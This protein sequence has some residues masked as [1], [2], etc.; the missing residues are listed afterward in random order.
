[1]ALNSHFG[2]IFDQFSINSLN[3]V[4]FQL[5]IVKQNEK[6]F[7]HPSNHQSLVELEMNF[8]TC[9]EFDR[10]KIKIWLPVEN[11]KF[12]FTKFSLVWG[13]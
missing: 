5:W 10:F 7:D 1:M 13:F 9:Q 8:A 12:K 4:A 6:R 2:V 3:E 11:W